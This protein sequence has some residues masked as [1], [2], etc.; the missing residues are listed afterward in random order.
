MIAGGFRVP[1]P[2]GRIDGASVLGQ[3][4]RITS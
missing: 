4:S 1:S 3:Y 2:G